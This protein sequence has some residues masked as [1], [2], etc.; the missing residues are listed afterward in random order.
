MELRSPEHVE[1]PG[2]LALNN[3]HADELSPETGPSFAKL[4]ATAWRVRSFPGA[5]GLCV[6]FDQ[7]SDRDS[8][9]LNWFRERFDKFAYVDRVVVDPAHRGKGLGRRFYTDVIDAARSQGY[10]LL[11]AEVNLDPPNPVSDAFHAGFGFEPAGQAALDGRDK[12][13]R[14]FTLRL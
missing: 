8:Q 10:P 11:C 5:A 6:A 4:L 14:Y 7:D 9:N 2:L 3:A 13:V 1:I 12:T